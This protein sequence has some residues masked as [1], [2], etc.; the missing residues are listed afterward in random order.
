MRSFVGADVSH[1]RARSGRSAG[2]P[3]GRVPAAGL[4]DLRRR[5]RRAPD[6]RAGDARRPA[7]PGC[8]EHPRRSGA[9]RR[10]PRCGG[11]WTADPALA[12]VEGG[13]FGWPPLLYLAYARHDPDVSADAV[14]DAVAV[15][16]RGRCR[17]GRRLP[18]ARQPAAVHRADR[19]LRRGRGRTGQ[20]AGAPAVGGAGPG[21]ARGGRRPE[22]RADALQP[23]VPSRRQPPRAALRVRARTA[24]EALLDQLAWAVDARVRRA[25]RSCCTGT[26]WTLGAG[27]CTAPARVAGP[28]GS[29]PGGRDA[30][31]RRI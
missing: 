5:R 29:W 18:V 12:N 23:D 3:G 31:R 30:V 22:R 21:A 15:L 7:R 16:T 10:R 9:D 19:R 25:R 1:A 17:P 24:D 6:Q 13:P 4:P 27:R 8:G 2:G 20:P 11:C 28:R 14:R 26:A